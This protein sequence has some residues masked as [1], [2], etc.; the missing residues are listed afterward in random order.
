VGK[1]LKNVDCA[2]PVLTPQ[3]QCSKL[4]TI[5]T[6]KRIGKIDVKKITVTKDKNLCVLAAQS[7]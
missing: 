2:P 4:L 5:C 6:T 7:W 1:L 3:L